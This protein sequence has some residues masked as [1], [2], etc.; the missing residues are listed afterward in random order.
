[1]AVKLLFLMGSVRSGGIHCLLEL[2]HIWFCIF[3]VL[4][5]R[6]NDLSVAIILPKANSLNIAIPNTSA[7]KRK[8]HMHSA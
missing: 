4:S 2:G 8:K 6:D 3:A 5:N 7:H 1:M